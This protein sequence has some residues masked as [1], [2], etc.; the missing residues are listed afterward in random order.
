MLSHEEERELERHEFYRKWGHWPNEE[1]CSFCGKAQKKNTMVTMET[2]L[3]SSYM[4]RLP[5]HWR[6]YLLCDDCSG[7]REMRET[8][9]KSGRSDGVP[10]QLPLQFPDV[11]SSSISKSRS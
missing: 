9:S 2:V 10:V 8:L 3:G 7:R 4:K 5:P 6:D 11:D 1:P